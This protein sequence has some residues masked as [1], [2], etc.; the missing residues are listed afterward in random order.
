[1][2]R[3]ASGSMGQFEQ[4]AAM[5]LMALGGEAY[6]LRIYDKMCEMN[7]KRV[8]RGGMYVSL[9]RLQKKGYPGCPGDGS[10]RRPLCSNEAMTFARSRSFPDIGTFRLR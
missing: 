3:A 8:Y 6:A 10:S 7:D 4:M 5:A 1:M 2:T 9:D